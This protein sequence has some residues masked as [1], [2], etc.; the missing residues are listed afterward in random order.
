MR[1][2]LVG[3]W[4]LLAIGL[5]G[6]Q[7]GA[8]PAAAVPAA[9]ASAAEPQAEPFKSY[10]LTIEGY[11]Y[12]DRYID[13]FTVNGQ[14]GGNVFLSTPTSGGGGGAC[15]V[16]WWTGTKLPKLVRIAWSASYCSMKEKTSYGEEFVTVQPYFK[17]VDVPIHG[18]IPKKPGY[19]EVHFY[20]DGH[21]EVAITEFPN[22]PRVQLPEGDSSVRA[23]TVANDPPC[24]AD[25]NRRH[26]FDKG[27]GSPPPSKEGQ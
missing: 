25:Y 10:S 27:L 13:H 5:C 23:G 15:C 19:F 4:L 2:G 7:P 18:P 20:K 22:L 11:N 21:V 16:S 17:V 26:E 3:T 14:G 12:T 6:C 1:S 8:G 24:P 9:A